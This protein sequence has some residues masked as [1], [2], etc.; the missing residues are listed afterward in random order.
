VQVGPEHVGGAA[1][2]RDLL[3]GGAAAV[4]PRR[5]AGG[6]R[7]GGAERRDPPR[8]PRQRVRP[9]G[10]LPEL[11]R[12]G[13]VG[14]PLRRRQVEALRGAQGPLRPAGDPRAGPEDLPQGPG[15]RRRAAVAAVGAGRGPAPG[16]R[17]EG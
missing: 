1:G 15:V 5:R 7:A 10:L 3:P 4:L 17:K 2:G 13:G 16:W 14:A 6:G 9:Q 8:V 11:P 12:G